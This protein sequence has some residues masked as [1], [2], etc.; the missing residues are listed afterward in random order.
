MAIKTYIAQETIRH[1]GKGYSPGD[2]IDLDD[3][4]A[5]QLLGLNAVVHKPA[6]GKKDDQE[7]GKQDDGQE[8]GQNGGQQAKPEAANPDPDD[9]KKAGRKASK[10]KKAK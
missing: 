7:P 6:G 4:S 3:K 2:E 8:A 10:G 1:N 9:G 5:S